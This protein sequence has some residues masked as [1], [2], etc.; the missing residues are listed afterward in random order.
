MKQLTP[1]DLIKH[2]SFAVAAS[3][4]RLFLFEHIGQLDELSSLNLNRP[5]MLGAG[6]N[7][8]FASDYPGDIILN[9]LL[10]RQTLDATDKHA[11]VRIQAG[12]NWHESVL[13]CLNLGL[14]GI[15]NLA[16]IP[17]TAGAAPVQNI[18]AYGVEIADYLVAVEAWDRQQQKAVML[19]NKV[20]DFTYRNSLFKQKNDRYWILNITLKL[21][22]KPRLHLGYQG[23]RAQLGQMGIESPTAKEVANAVIALRKEKLPDPADYPNAGSFFKNPLVSYAQLAGLLK[24]FPEIPHWPMPDNNHKLA[25]AWLIEKCGWKGKRCGAAGVSPEHALILVNYKHASGRAIE[26]L[27]THI[28]QSVF[29]QFGLQLEAEPRIIHA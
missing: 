4:K 9:Q 14:S 17:G 19:K 6:S 28:Q 2:N 13:W 1:P 27:A 26:K 16:L 18:G 23:I 12:E 21:N 25:A 3:C 24:Q 5:L 15:E 22:R 20:C 7:I 8:L 11:Y 10:G 29:D